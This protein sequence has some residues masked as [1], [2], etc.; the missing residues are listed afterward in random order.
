MLTAVRRPRNWLTQPRT[1][2]Q[3]QAN[4]F[5][6]FIALR[7]PKALQNCRITHIVSVLEWQFEPDNP[8]TRGFQHLHI[9]V[10]DVEDENLLTWFP[11]SNAFVHDALTKWGPKKDASHGANSAPALDMLDSEQGNGVFIHW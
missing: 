9:P 3:P 11:R 10:D 7:R 8:L 1:T 4:S 6:S 5:A 2:Q